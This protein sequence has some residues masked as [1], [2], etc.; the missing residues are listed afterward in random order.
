MHIDI[1]VL[2]LFNGAGIKVQGIGGYLKHMW[3]PVWWL[4]VLLFAIE[5]LSFLLVGGIH[6]PSKQMSPMLLVN[7]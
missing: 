7:L 4:G 1:G 2:I 5:L 3:G 6:V